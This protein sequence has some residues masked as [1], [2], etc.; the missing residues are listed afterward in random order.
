MNAVRKDVSTSTTF[1]GSL[2]AH[3]T[4]GVVRVS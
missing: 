2:E 1:Q 4:T 3:P